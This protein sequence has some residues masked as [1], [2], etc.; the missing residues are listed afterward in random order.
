[1][2]LNILVYYSR[3]VPKR[4]ENLGGQKDPLVRSRDQ[5]WH[6]RASVNGYITK[7]QRIN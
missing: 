6:V 2:E 3:G 5:N 1:V 7:T 4:Y